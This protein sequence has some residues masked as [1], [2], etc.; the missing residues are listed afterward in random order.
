MHNVPKGLSTCMYKVPNMIPCGTTGSESHF[1]VVV[2]SDKFDGVPLIKV[3]YTY[4]HIR[5]SSGPFFEI[6]IS[7]S[8]RPS[9]FK[10]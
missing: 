5:Y 7:H 4:Q 9:T 8:L 1:K 2:V 6:Q 10:L 3:H